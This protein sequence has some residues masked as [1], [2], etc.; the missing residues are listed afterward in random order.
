MVTIGN[1]VGD[2]VGDIGDYGAADD[3]GDAISTSKK[4]AEAAS[5]QGRL[6]CAASNLK[7]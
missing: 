3:D 1:D 6:P 2:D 7:H 5:F 4:I